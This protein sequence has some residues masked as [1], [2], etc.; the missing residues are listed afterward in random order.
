VFKL[1]RR[2]HEIQ[3]PKAVHSSNSSSEEGELLSFTT[4]ISRNPEPLRTDVKKQLG[5]ENTYG[6]MIN[7]ILL[8]KAEQK[9]ITHVRP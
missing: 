3:E 4:V 1:F 5:T 7:T 9:D 2:R 6:E 8:T